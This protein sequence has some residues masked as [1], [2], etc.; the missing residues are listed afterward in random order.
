MEET[1]EYSYR[2]TVA[3]NQTEA[4]TL[5]KSGSKVEK[6]KVI[7]RAYQLIWYVL[8]VVEVLLAF[9]FGLRLLGASFGSPFVQLIYGLTDGLVGPFRGILISAVSGRSVWEW[10]TI[11]AMAVYYFAAYG[12]VYLFQFVKP[13]NPLEVQHTLD[14]V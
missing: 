3:D 11:V 7:F 5:E 9:R 13:T 8:G 1:E 12:L 6:R 4:E 14:K 10:S 2:E